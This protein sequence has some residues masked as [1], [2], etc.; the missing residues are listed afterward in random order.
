MLNIYCGGS[1]KICCKDNHAVWH[2]LIFAS[3]WRPYLWFAELMIEHLQTPKKCQ[4]RGITV[5]TIILHHRI[6][7][8][9]AHPLHV[10]HLIRVRLHR[11]RAVHLG[12]ND[13]SRLGKTKLLKTAWVYG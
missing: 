2:I 13:E 8:L 12:R 3:D 11:N 10:I 6:H 1:N 7:F 5:H 4:R 9:K